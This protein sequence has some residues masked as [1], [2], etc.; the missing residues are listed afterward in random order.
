VKFV[1]MVFHYPE[2]SH[3]DSLL[4]GMSEMTSSFKGNPGFIDAGAWVDEA[5]PDRIVGIS[6]WES[7]Q[8]FFD[9]GI[10]FGDPDEIVAGEI[11]PRERFFLDRH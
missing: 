10:V 6:L 1:F 7:R 11:R 4:K 8:S 9:S 5:T 3:R 2:S